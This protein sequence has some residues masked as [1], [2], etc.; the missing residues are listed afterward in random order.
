M[1]PSFRKLS[2][3]QT[4]ALRSHQDAARAEIAREYDDYLADF[5]AGDHGRAEL[6][7]GEQRDMVRRELQAAAGRRG[8]VL[9]FR[10]GR[11]PLTFH[12]EPLPAPATSL[13]PVAPAPAPARREEDAPRERPAPQPTTRRQPAGPAPARREE[14]APRER[15]APQP[16]TRRQPVAGRYDA[17]L[18]RWMR[19][20][21]QPAQRTGS[22][23]RGRSSK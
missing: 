3:A 14:D 18:P 1:M 17:M 2:A 7:D 15:P 23:R 22:K 20:G 10:A 19:E 21:Q 8:L 6:R 11:G 9:R 16:T 4:A 13:D 5:A 12:I